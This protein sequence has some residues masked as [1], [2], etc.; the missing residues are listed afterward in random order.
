MFTSGNEEFW[1]NTGFL[2]MAGAIFICQG[3]CDAHKKN[4]GMHSFSEL[5]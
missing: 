4:V 1:E 5:T 2:E 3:E